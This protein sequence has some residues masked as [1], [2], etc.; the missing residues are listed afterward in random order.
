MKATR[1]EQLS[2]PPASRRLPLVELL[3]ALAVIAGLVLFWRHWQEGATPASPDLEVPPAADFPTPA[4]TDLPPAPDIP[5]RDA[6]T[7]PPDPRADGPAAETGRQPVT[8]VAEPAQPAPLSP[9]EGDELL[10]RELAQAGSLPALEKLASS[11]RPLDATAALI[12]G[13]GRGLI[14]R[15]LLPLSPPNPGFRIEKRGEVIY[16]DPANYRRYNGF[17]EA[18]SS[19]DTARVVESF[20][21]LRPLYESAY[22]KLGLDSEDFDNAI[23]RALDQAL[24]TPEISEPIALKPKAVVYVYADPALEALPDLQKQLLRMGPD[25]IRLIKQQAKSLRDALLTQ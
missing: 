6:P 25:N 13:L 10:R 2:P 8:P 18:V 19:L 11:A 23:I 7:A 12:D 24:A 21:A 4:V 20:H 22:G 17:A 1:D 16:L 5:R 3:L 14:L 15:K 9:G